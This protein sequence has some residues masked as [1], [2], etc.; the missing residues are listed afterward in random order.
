MP[1]GIIPNHSKGKIM[2]AVIK[3]GFGNEE[4]R[5]I[6]GDDDTLD[7]D[8]WAD[9]YANAMGI[10]LSFDD[11]DVPDGCEDF[12]VVITENP[13]NGAVCWKSKNY[14]IVGE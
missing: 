2:Y 5:I 14:L 8:F 10:L 6:L 12:S 3:D 9:K 11:G 7:P 1:S 13:D 4:T